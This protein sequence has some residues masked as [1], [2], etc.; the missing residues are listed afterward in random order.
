MFCTYLQVSVS[1]Y[2]NCILLLFSHLT[3]IIIFNYNDGFY[4]FYNFLHSFI[5]IFNQ[6]DLIVIRMLLFFI[7]CHL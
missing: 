6:H 7:K 1:W 5:I 3:R 4:L 2:H